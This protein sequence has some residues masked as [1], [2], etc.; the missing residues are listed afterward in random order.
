MH[1]LLELLKLSEKSGPPGQITSDAGERRDR[2]AASNDQRSLRFWRPSFCGSAH[3]RSIGF[4][5]LALQTSWRGA[6]V[7]CETPDSCP[8]GRLKRL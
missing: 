8:P 4:K 1:R 5:E 6:R 3:R 7:E 2:D